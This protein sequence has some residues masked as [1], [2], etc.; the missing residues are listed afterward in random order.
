MNLALLRLTLHPDAP[1][2][3]DATK[4]R[5]FFVTGFNAGKLQ[6]EP[7]QQESNANTVKE[8]SQ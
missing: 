3:G 8:T 1:M 6:E 2:R 5:G 7:Q 4:L